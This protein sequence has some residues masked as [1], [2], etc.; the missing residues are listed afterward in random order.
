MKNRTRSG[1]TRSGETRLPG[2]YLASQSPRRRQILTELGIPFSVITSPYEE[3]NSDLVDLSPA[4]GAAKLASLKAFFAAKS[5]DE[6][7]VIGADT[8]VV[9]GNR[10]M[11]KPKDKAEAKEMLCALSGKTH[12]VITGISIVDVD[13]MR[14]LSHSESTRVVFRKLASRESGIYTDSPEPY[15]KAGA[16]AIQGFA[17][18]FIERIEGC[19][20]NVVGF[21]IA[22]FDKLLNRINLRLLDYLVSG[23]GKNQ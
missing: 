12:S 1:E 21:P 13:G 14:T 11:G 16:Y 18:L 17:S 15:D 5:L 2:L 23:A 9:L 8:I 20:Y 19:Y 22:A 10:I 6:G 7:I 4:D 3:R